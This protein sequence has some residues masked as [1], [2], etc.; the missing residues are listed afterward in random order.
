[1]AADWF[2]E[3]DDQDMFRLTLEAKA[4]GRSLEEHLRRLIVEHVGRRYEPLAAADI[5]ATDRPH[6][7]FDLC[8]R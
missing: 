1:M 8:E 7:I 6:L 4:S 5:L 2:L 3:L